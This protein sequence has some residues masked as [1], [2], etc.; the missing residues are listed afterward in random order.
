MID[1]VVVSSDLRPYVLDTRVKRGAE[2]SID[3]HLVVSWLHWW[4]RMPIRPGR[5][6]RVVRVCWERLSESPVRRSFNSHL[7]QRFN[8]VLG[9][10][11]DIES[12]WAM[13]SASIVEAADR[14]C[15]HKVVGACRGGNRFR[16]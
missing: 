7:R 6:K 12:E 10:V 14:S 2:L 9:E 13:F 11:G 3:H 15:G 1:F 16:G 5:P 8:H 4:G